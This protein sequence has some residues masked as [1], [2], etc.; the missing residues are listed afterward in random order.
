VPCTLP[1]IP[2]SML[3]LP[4]KIIEPEASNEPVN[5]I[6]S[7]FVNN[8]FCPTEPYKFVEPETVNEPFSNTLPEL[9]AFVVIADSILS[10]ALPD[11]LKNT[12]P[13]GTF[14]AN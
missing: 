2:P 5:S 7:A 4:V 11:F 8:T 3:K 1:V 6:V 13:S 12:R 10:P 9:F 14:M